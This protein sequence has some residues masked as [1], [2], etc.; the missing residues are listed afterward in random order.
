MNA[1]VH[2]HIT[3]KMYSVSVRGKVVAYVPEIALAQAVFHVD[4]RLRTKFEARPSRRTVHALVRGQ[5][6]TYAAPPT[7]M[8]ASILCN[9]FLY[10]GFVRATD[11]AVAQTADL[12]LLSADRSMEAYGLACA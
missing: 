4:Q 11:L 3:K 2:W 6:V 10:R 7:G 8:A 5:I 9:P 1:K 12:V